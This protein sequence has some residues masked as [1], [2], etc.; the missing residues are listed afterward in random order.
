MNAFDSSIIHFLHKLTAQSNL[1]ESFMILI[2][3]NDFLKGAIVVSLLWYL[4]FKNSTKINEN[5]ERIVITL[6][7]CIAAIFV[8]RLLARILPYRF[9][10]ILNP[11]VSSN[12]PN[13]TVIHGLELASSFPSDHAVLF[14]SLGTGIFL[15]SKKAGL[16]AYLYV[17]FTICFPRIYLGLHYPTDILAGAVVG[18]LITLLLSNRKM[19]RPITNPILNFSIKYSGLFYILFFLISFQISTLFQSGRSIIHFV[20]GG[21]YENLF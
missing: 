14:F 6:I 9:R 18:V 3:D 21:L 5:R 15:I 8:G 10:P 17:F 20:L 11:E 2:V 13:K 16:L 12:F 7:S 4:W 1:F 19:W